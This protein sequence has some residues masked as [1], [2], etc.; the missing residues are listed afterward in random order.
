LIEAL[1]DPEW[2]VRRQTAVALGKIGPA[3]RA[4]ESELRRCQRDAH[5]L[6]RKAATEA[7]TRIKDAPASERK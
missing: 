4:A 6:V 3:A 5:T 2:A 7:L 1:R